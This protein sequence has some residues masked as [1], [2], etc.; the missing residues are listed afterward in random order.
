M[1][2][3]SS[4]PEY[5]SKARFDIFRSFETTAF[6]MLYTLSLVSLVLL[7]LLSAA[8]Y[9]E[10]WLPYAPSYVR[11]YLG[12]YAAL[13]SFASAMEAGLSTQTFDLRENEDDSRTGM[14]AA[15]LTEVRS[16]TGQA[17]ES[18]PTLGQVRRLMDRYSISFDE[19]R[20]RRQQDIFR[21][22]GSTSGESEHFVCSSRVQSTRIRA[23]QWTRRPSVPA[24]SLASTLIF[25]M[26]GHIPLAP[27][28]RFV[29]SSVH[30]LHLLYPAA[31]LS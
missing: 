30:I 8:Y 17:H 27:A 20:L 29:G 22:N 21:R 5:A 19:A 11:S 15:G 9:R 16:G 6:Q 23:C 26:A 13:P 3:V 1:Q 12:T 10:Q 4:P 14:D 25:C 2:E 31:S 24:R 28:P 18:V 7:L